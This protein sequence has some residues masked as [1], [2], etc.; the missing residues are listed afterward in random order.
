MHGLDNY[1]VGFLL[2]VGFKEDLQ[3]F[4]FEMLCFPGLCLISPWFITLVPARGNCLRTWLWTLHPHMIWILPMVWQQEPIPQIQCFSLYLLWL[5]LTL[6]S[7][8]QQ[9]QLGTFWKSRVLGSTPNLPETPGWNL[10]IS[11]L[12]SPP[13]G[14]EV[15]SR[16]EIS[17]LESR[18]I[19][20]HCNCG[21]QSPA[22]PHPRPGKWELPRVWT[23]HRTIL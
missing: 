3:T 10:A 16:L 18:T 21:I 13:G 23:K 15:C 11:F 9:L 22:R 1:A 5:A 20:S 6:L 14:S 17:A 7:R 4:N 8:Y 19:P 12:T 2:V